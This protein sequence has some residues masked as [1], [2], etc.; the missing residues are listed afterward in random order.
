MLAKFLRNY[1][2][3]IKKYQKIFKRD[4]NIELVKF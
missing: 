2:I 1:V 4:E 3:L